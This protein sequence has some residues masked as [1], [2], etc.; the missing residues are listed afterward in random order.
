MNM[1]NVITNFPILLLLLAGCN[2][3]LDITPEDTLV[4]REVFSNE[5]AT[6]Q[7]LAD[8]YINLFR[9]VTGNMAYVFGDFSTGNL[10]HSLFYDTYDDGSVIPADEGVQAIWANYYRAINLGNNIMAKVPQY[11]Q[12]AT[13]KQAQFIAEARFLRAY[14]YLALLKL[15][16]E[17]ALAGRL[18]GLGVP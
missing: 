8:S 13:S 9:A 2:R 18:A 14:A 15:F 7:V 5:L 16:C 3:Q 17:G 4:D 1:K 12:Y 11:A 6:E 10:E